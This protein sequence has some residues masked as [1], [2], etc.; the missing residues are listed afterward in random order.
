MDHIVKWV[1][2]NWILSGMVALILVVALYQH[3]A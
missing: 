3:L 1:K 2:K